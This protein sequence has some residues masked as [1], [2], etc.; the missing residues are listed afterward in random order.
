[1][2]KE[3]IQIEGKWEEGAEDKTGPKREGL[4]GHLGG[5]WGTVQYRPS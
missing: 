1:M 5:G 3:G 4:T 2:K